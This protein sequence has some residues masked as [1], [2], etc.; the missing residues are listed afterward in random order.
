M[1]DDII[2]L[3]DEIQTAIVDLERSISQ[4]K[5]K[6]EKKL[7]RSK[8]NELMIKLYA[9]RSA[10]QRIEDANQRNIYKY[11]Y[12]SYTDKC[13]KFDNSITTLIIKKNLNI[14]E[15]IM[16]GDNADVSAAQV[17]Q[18]ANKAQDDIND[19]L[20]K[21]LHIGITIKDEQHE[22]MNTIAK[23]TEKI[24]QIEHGLETA[25]GEITRAKKDIMWFFRRLMHDKCCIIITFMLVIG[26]C[27][28]IGW[29]IYNSK[30]TNDGALPINVTIN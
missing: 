17:L 6:K 3:D 9:Y 12:S 28:L 23:Q 24:Y 29:K 16:R 30:Q 1:V 26:T 21:S 27:A 22:V 18:V 25:G 7:L 4:V 19:S 2:T 5:H 14:E 13:S 11:K 8:Y 10:I 15:K 20:R